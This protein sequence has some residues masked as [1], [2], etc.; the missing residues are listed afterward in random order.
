[1]LDPRIY[2]TGFIGVALAVIVFAFSLETQP[3]GMG[4]TLSSEAFNGGAV[5]AAIN[6]LAAQ[7]PDRR[8]GSGGDDALAG[9]VGQVLQGDGYSVSTDTFK[10]STADGARTLETVSGVRAGLSNGTIVIVSHRDAQSSPAAADLSGTAAMLELARVL[11][12]ETLSHTVMLVSTS[13]SVG[14]VGTT[15]LARQ[16]AGSQL[17][18]V[19]V[20]GDLAGSDVTQPVVGP[21]SNGQKIAPPALRNTLAAA[22]RSQAGLRAGGNGVG[23]QLARLAFPLTITEQGPFGVHGEPA[24]LVS[25]AGQRVPRRDERVSGGRVTALGRA[26]LVTVNAIDRGS[27]IAAPSSYLLFG[28]KLV[29]LWAVRLLVLALIVPVLMATIDGIA[30]ARRRGHPISRWIVWVLSSAVPFVLVA[31]IVRGAKLA[32]VLDATPPGPVGAGAVPLHGAGIALL[33]V[34]ALV[35]VL[36]FWL[37]RPLCLRLVARFAGPPGTRRGSAGEGAGAAVLLVI[38]VAALAIWLANPFAAALMIPALHLWMWVVDPDVRIPR[39]LAAVMILI[40]L[41]PPLLVV[42]YYAHALG[43]SPVD[44]IWNGALLIAGG[45]LGILAA[46]QWSVVLGCVA[47]VAVILRR[48]ERRA[49]PEESEVISVRGPMGYAGPGSLGGTESALRR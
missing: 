44:V 26:V 11:K 24:V 15:R 7:Y 25:V 30:R 8:P 12:G 2:R 27:P 34:L 42:V 20:L 22:L 31:A 1:M 5:Y 9:H 41:A 21:W 16:L 39:S 45:Q 36:S 37:L 43:L 47:S 6:N 40:G 10:G 38:C 18:A 3:G 35:L 29:P 19:I 28:G 48:A 33:A 23:A 14:A 49:G 46:V 13:G 17:D 4:T 32:G